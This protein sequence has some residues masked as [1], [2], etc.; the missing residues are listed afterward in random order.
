MMNTFMIVNITPHVRDS[1]EDTS[2]LSHSKKSFLLPSVWLGA[3]YTWALIERRSLLICFK[4]YRSVP[5]FRTCRADRNAN[6]LLMVTINPIY[7]R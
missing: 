4:S 2:M 1:L 5:Y 3:K 7:K 6:P